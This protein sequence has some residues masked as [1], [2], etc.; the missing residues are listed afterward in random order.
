MK[1]DVVHERSLRDRCRSGTGFSIIMGSKCLLLWLRV[2]LFHCSV[3]N[4]WYV[5]V[6]PYSSGGAVCHPQSSS[7]I[8]IIIIK[9]GGVFL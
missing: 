7:T 9:G 4:V 8:T 5:V 2:P 3:Q 1:I 6:V